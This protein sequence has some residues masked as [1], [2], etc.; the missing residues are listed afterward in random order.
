ML[1]GGLLAQ[2]TTT[3]GKIKPQLQ[4]M[5]TAFQITLKCAQLCL[6]S[7]YIDKRN[8]FYVAFV[9]L[10]IG[11]WQ[12]R[13]RICIY[14]KLLPGSPAWVVTLNHTVNNNLTPFA[15]AETDMYSKQLLGLVSACAIE[16]GV[17][18][19][20]SACKKSLLLQ[21]NHEQYTAYTGQMYLLLAS[22]LTRP[23]A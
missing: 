13:V 5:R 17:S 22:K 14:G 21:L 16:N 12:R 7:S 11:A 10:Y 15:I 20:S 2:S 4:H 19:L 18:H 1:S 6:H 8:S 9:C 23:V 3:H